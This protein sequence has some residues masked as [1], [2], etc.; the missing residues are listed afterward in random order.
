MKRF[1]IF[2]FICAS[3]SFIA[4]SQQ[5][6]TLVHSLDEVVVTAQNH[7]AISHGIAYIP[8]QSD[9]K[10]SSNYLELLGQMMVPGLIN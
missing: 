3:I 10:H 8:Q 4:Y 9:K 6:T 7:Q 5:D 1:I 2:F